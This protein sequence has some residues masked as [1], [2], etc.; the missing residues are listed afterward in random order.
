MD[1]STRN[2]PNSTASGERTYSFNLF[3]QPGVL[4]KRLIWKSINAESSLIQEDDTPVGSYYT[5]D[6]EFAELW[7]FLH[8]MGVLALQ[9][10]VISMIMEVGKVW[11]TLHSGIC[12]TSTAKLQLTVN[13]ANLWFYWSLGLVTSGIFPSRNSSLTSFSSIWKSTGWIFCTTCQILTTQKLRIS[14]S[15]LQ[16]QNRQLETTDYVICSLRFNMDSTDVQ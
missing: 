16:V 15:P 3:T 9:D 4:Q 2:S 11:E 7:G 13:F 5:E 14:S 6:M 10:F 12:L 1:V 8:K